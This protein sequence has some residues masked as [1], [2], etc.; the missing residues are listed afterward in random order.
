MAHALLS[1]PVEVRRRVKAVIHDEFVFS[2]PADR[3]E[4]MAASI[5]EA[6][7]FDLKGVAITFGVSK[8]SFAWS[9]CYEK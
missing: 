3:A 8:P 5:A 2:L 6:M 4:S 1:L 9:G 7:S